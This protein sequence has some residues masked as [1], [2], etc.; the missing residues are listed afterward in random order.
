MH[1]RVALDLKH[2][3][4]MEVM[5]INWF[6]VHWNQCACMVLIDTGTL[7]TNRN[8]TDSLLAAEVLRSISQLCRVRS[9]V[10]ENLFA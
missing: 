9:F 6:I 3:Y 5:G 8:R 10:I 4:H 1:T 7:L 2:L